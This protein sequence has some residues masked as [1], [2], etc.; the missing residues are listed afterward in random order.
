M[1]R[2]R[3]V[4]LVVSIFAS[5]L[6]VGCSSPQREVPE[7]ATSQ[8]LEI[9]DQ[10][11][12]GKASIQKVNDAAADLSERPR[13]DLNP[14]ITRLST[15]LDSL[16][17]VAAKSRTQ[18]QEADA[19]AQAYF[20]KWE[21]QIRTMSDDVAKSAERR[22]AEARAS[23]AKLTD[24]INELKPLYR[25]Y[26]ADLTEAEKYLKTDPTAPGLGVVQ[27]KLKDAIKHEPA[28]QRKI[29]ETIA[30]IDRIRAGK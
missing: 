12:E 8:L 24:K 17:T 18:A 23:Y 11:T 10:L 26:V 15:E 3:S 6:V 7:Q 27:P 14:Q 20:T 22:Q 25:G 2:V 16:R 5:Y 4:S 21:A 29:D 19:E 13:S 30:E 1:T 9:R 28:L